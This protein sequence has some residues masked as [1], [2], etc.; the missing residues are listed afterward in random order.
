MTQRDYQNAV[1]MAK[2]Y[3][4]MYYVKSNPVISDAEFDA[5]VAQIEQAESEHPEWTLPDSPTQKVG[6]DLKEGRAWIR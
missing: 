5:L 6:S 3:S 2:Y 4:H 1:G